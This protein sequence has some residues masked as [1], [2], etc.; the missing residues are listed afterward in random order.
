MTGGNSE[1][2]K[3]AFVGKTNNDM[4]SDKNVEVDR[5]GRAYVLTFSLKLFTAQFAQRTQRKTLF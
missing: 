5:L 3:E 1:E 4:I 2:R